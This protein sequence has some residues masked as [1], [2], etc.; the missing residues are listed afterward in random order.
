M[1]RFVLI[2]LCIVPLEFCIA[3]EGGN[4]IAMRQSEMGTY[5]V[6]VHIEGLQSTEFL[7]DTGSSH[8]VINENTLAALKT[9]GTAAYAYDMKAIMADGTVKTVPV[10]SIQ[11]IDIGRHCVLTN[12]EA[13]VF[14]GESRQILGLSTL[15]KASSFIFTMS[16]PS[17]QLSACGGDQNK[18][19]TLTQ[20]SALP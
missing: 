9:N 18:G 10:Y 5:Y 16:P 4:A 15:T 1:R 11:S 17:L 12:V 19:N 6:A 13:A 2:I 3:G 8:T 14:P 20:V 7:I